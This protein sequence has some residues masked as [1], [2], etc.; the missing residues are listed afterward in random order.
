MLMKDSEKPRY[1]YFSKTRDLATNNCSERCIT[2]RKEDVQRAFIDIDEQLKQLTKS[3][4]D[5]SKVRRFIIIQEIRNRLYE[6]CC[7]CLYGLDTRKFA[8]H[9]PGSQTPL[10][11]EC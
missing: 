6:L 11:S 9:K 5:I 1:K 4:D 3:Y 10:N 2:F 8:S 7:M